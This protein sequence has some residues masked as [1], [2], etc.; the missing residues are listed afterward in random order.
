MDTM[1]LIH[2]NICTTLHFTTLCFS[3]LIAFREQRQLESSS[4]SSQTARQQQSGR[5]R[6]QQRHLPAA[7]RLFPA[8]ELL[9]RRQH[10]QQQAVW[11]SIPR[12]PTQRGP[13]G[14]EASRDS[15]QD[16]APR[17]GWGG[18]QPVATAGLEILTDQQLTD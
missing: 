12:A 13:V 8:K 9:R 3:V 11:H 4:H 5:T 18:P 16:D 10:R 15:F 7:H 17:R 14:R 1:L 6:R 2:Y